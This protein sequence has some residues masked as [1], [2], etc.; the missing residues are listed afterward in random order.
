MVTVVCAYFAYSAYAQL[1][2]GDFFWR[3]DWWYSVTWVVWLIFVIA[4][5]T[6]TQ[7]LRERI[8]FAFAGLNFAIGALFTLW[9]SVSTGTAHAARVTSLVIWLLATLTGVTTFLR[10]TTSGETHV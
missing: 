7:C 1:C 9:T 2:D 6:E 10:P 3:D 8:L 4:L 5:M